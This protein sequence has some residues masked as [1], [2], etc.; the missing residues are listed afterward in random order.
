[1]SAADLS[2]NPIQDLSDEPGARRVLWRSVARSLEGRIGVVLAVLI[3]AVVIFGPA[4]APYAP[5]QIGFEPNQRSS[6]EHLFGTDNLGRD[7]LSRVLNG[8]RSVVL[9]PL[10]GVT[11]AFIIGGFLGMLSAY[12]GGTVDRLFARAVDLLLALPALLMVLVLIAG[13]GRS[14]TVIVVS[15]VV[16]FVPRIARIIRGA[17]QAVITHDYVVAAQARGER[18]SAILIREVLPNIAAPAIAEY[19]LRL[20]WA[21][22]FVST[23]SFLGL[24]AQPPSSDWG[25]M[26]SENR[27]YLSIAPLGTYAP[28]AGIALFAVS[29]S[30]IADALTRQ[31]DPNSSKRAAPL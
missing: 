17:T 21:L 30:L 24:G 1:M 16:L 3:L 15:M 2:V 8:G 10:I 7:V 23:L 12:K 22:L 29:L 28:A 5:D 27:T 14:D 18:T 19:T 13:F 9:I 11:F 31:L 4:V 25:L 6:S 26:V 20:T